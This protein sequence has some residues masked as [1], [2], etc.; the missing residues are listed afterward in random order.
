MSFDAAWLSLREPAD[1][2]ARNGRLVDVLARHLAAKRKPLILDIGCGTGATFRSLSGKVSAD[3]EW[4]MLDNDP[5]LLEEAQRRTGAGDRVSFRRHDLNDL[6]GLPLEDAAMVT[7]SALFDLCSLAY[8]AALA[9]RLAARGCGLYAALNYDG[10]I[11][12]SR[13]HALD[14]DV[15]AAFNRHQKTDKGF[16]PALGP[17]AAT[18]LSNLFKGHGFRVETEHSPWRM[19]RE[20]AALQRAFIAGFRQP[21]EAVGGFTSKDIADWIAFRHAAIEDPDSLCSVGHIDLLALPA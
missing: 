20:S 4:L 9:D 17:D 21:L 2:A 8:S 15:V 6:D 18:E 16:G 5:L 13:P 3:A 11:H 14:D 12:W 19:N 1:R 7:A 10:R